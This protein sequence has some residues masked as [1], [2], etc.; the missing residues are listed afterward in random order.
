MVIAGISHFYLY[1]C[2]RHDS[3]F[4]TS[5][6]SGTHFWAALNL[7]IKEKHVKR[8]AEFPVD[9]LRRTGRDESEGEEAAARPRS[10]SQDSGRSAQ[11]SD[12]REAY[13]GA[14]RALQR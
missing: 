2:V 5:R 9:P 12:R 8:T 1:A 14:D 11:V 13:Q 3:L 4:G 6:A 10:R 7:S